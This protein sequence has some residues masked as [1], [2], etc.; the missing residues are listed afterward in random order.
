MDVYALGGQRNIKRIGSRTHRK[1]EAAAN[2]KIANIE[3]NRSFQGGSRREA[4][5]GSGGFR[6][7]HLL[8]IPTLHA[9]RAIEFAVL[10]SEI[11]VVQVQPIVFGQDAIDNGGVVDFV[12]F[13]F[14]I[15]QDECNGVVPGEF[16][17]RRVDGNFG[18]FFQLHH[19]HI[20]LWICNFAL[21]FVD[22]TIGQN[23]VA[24]V[25]QKQLFFDALEVWNQKTAT[26]VIEQPFDGY[27]ILECPVGQTIRFEVV[28]LRFVHRDENLRAPT[29]ETEKEAEEKEEQFRR[30]LRHCFLC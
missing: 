8:L 10:P 23:L 1:Q 3:R 22:L 19:F 5:L 2:H 20:D 9:C 16:I 12:V 25:A 7:L 15:G 29:L 30:D 4:E 26:A 14:S 17:G 11:F 24:N 6:A 27:L 18:C 13:D 28:A 21:D